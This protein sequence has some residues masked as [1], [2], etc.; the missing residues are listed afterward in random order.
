MKKSL[1]TLVTLFVVS[2][3][4]FAQLRDSVLVEKPIFRIMYSE[5]K[6][7]PLW[8]EYTVRKIT[9]GADRKGMDFFEESD[10]HTSNNYDYVSNEWDKGH[11][12]PAAH[13]ADTKQ[14]LAQTFTYLNS[15]LQHQK[16]N[17]VQWRLLEEK[18]REW[19][20]VFGELDVRVDVIF[21]DVPQVLPTGAEIPDA[22]YKRIYFR[23]TQK[24][25]CYYFLNEPPTKPWNEYEVECK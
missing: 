4:T 22:F 16:L 2:Q 8:V 17:R 5:T 19:A 9:K 7:Q 15:A 6:E 1:L 18:E 10:Y 24:W 11:M 23:S 12:A 14:N 25:Q 21:D 3:T 20:E 13:F